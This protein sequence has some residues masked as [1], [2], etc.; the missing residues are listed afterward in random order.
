M[1]HYDKNLGVYLPGDTK[2]EELEKKL[3]EKPDLPKIYEEPS[4]EPIVE[5]TKTISNPYHYEL[6]ED[7]IPWWIC[8][9]CGKAYNSETVQK[10]HQTLKHK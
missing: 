6:D 8:N 2:E 9:T 1:A 3:F 5:I 10:R 7:E 4:K